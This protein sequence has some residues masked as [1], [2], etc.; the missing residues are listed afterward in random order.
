MKTRHLLGVVVIALC[1]ACTDSGEPNERR[2]DRERD[3]L[4]AESRLPG[5][6]GV[7]SALRAQDRASATNAKI[8]S[9]AGSMER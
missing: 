7:G 4:I 2:T 3:S 6:S 1:A 9:I 5:A 8:D